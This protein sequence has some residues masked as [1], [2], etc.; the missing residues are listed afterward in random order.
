MNFCNISKGAT[1]EVRG[2]RRFWPGGIAD[3][4]GQIMRCGG[5]IIFSKMNVNI[6]GR[7]HVWVKE[8]CD[9]GSILA[10]SPLL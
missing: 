7:S 3:A 6:F 8:M 5:R 2:P 10:P 9:A 1:E 4:E